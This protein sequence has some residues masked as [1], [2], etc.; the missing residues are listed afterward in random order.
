M[1]KF[2]LFAIFCVSACQRS[3]APDAGSSATAKVVTAAPASSPAPTTSA[4]QNPGTAFSFDADPAGG[5]PSGFV[6]G[7]TGQGPAGRWLVQTDGSAKTAPNV[8]VQLDADATNFRFP[9]AVTQQA[10]PANVAVSVS[11]KMI[12]GRVDQACGLVLRYRDE[13]NYLMTRANALEDNVR[14]YTVKDGKREELASRDVEVTSGAWHAYRF[15][16]RAEALRVFWGGTLVLEHRNET[17]LGAGAVGVW[18]KADSITAFDDL[19][20]EPLR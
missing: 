15:E 1:R 14:L 2:V 5:P 8:L 11:C 19:L 13:N 3:R 10:Q 7:R 6:F 4:P 9:L 16:A 12:S 20:V 17:F 18:T